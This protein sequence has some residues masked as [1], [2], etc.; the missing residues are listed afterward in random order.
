MLQ[1]DRI[2]ETME[3]QFPK[4]K[5]K[6]LTDSDDIFFINSSRGVPK[7]SIIKFSWW[8][9]AFAKAPLY[10]LSNALISSIDILF[11]RYFYYFQKQDI[12]NV[13]PISFFACR[14]HRHTRNVYTHS[15]TFY[16]YSIYKQLLN[17]NVAKCKQTF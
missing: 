5:L 4:K 2:I 17:Y 7:I 11:I 8:I 15:H 3:C 13:S 6:L 12:P 10:I 1:S 14:V 9:S 16:S